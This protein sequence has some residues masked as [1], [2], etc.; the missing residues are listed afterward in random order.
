V[1]PNE[2]LVVPLFRTLIVYELVADDAFK[3]VMKF[4]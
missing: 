4:R 3:P 1:T 2:D